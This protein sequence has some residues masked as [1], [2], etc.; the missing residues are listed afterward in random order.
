[1][2]NTLLL[3]KEVKLIGNSAHVYLPKEWAGLVVEIK[4]KTPSLESIKRG[5]ISLVMEQHG[6]LLKNIS[7]IYL[8]G[9]I[10]RGEQT[11]AS[12]I[13]ILIVTDTEIKAEKSTGKYDISYATLGQIKKTL[14]NNAVM[15]LPMLRE[16]EPLLNGALIKDLAKSKVNYKNTKWFLQ[17]TQSSLKIIEGLIKQERKDSIPNIVY[18]LVMRLRGIYLVKCLT[19]EKSYSNKEFRA[20]LHKSSKLDKAEI[21]DIYEVYRAVRDE[22][23]VPKNNI[24]Y[25]QL[26]KLLAVA[27][28]ELS[29]AEKWLRRKG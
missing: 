10:A 23:E 9:S 13:D 7:G 16:A 26:K 2:A 12:D 11:P 28:E 29:E 15:I 3:E 25:Q 5:V 20:Y 18:P 1:M 14:E 19:R 8:H 21:K 4:P 6:D 27:W 22:K 24:D 17:T